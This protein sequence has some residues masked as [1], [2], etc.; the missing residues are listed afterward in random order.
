MSLV[1]LL[2]VSKSCDQSALSPP[3]QFA[4]FDLGAL[5]PFVEHVLPPMFRNF[6]KVIEYVCICN[7]HIFVVAE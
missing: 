1:S 7:F 5:P 2:Y 3:S 6:G 4:F